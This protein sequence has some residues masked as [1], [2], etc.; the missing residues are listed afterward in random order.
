MTEM[1]DGSQG[2]I[3]VVLVTNTPFKCRLL[4]N[5]KTTAEPGFGDLFPNNNREKMMFYQ[6]LSKPALGL[7]I[8]KS[9][10]VRVRQTLLAKPLRFFVVQDHLW[11]FAGDK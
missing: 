5:S 1:K 3:P 4:E 9:P 7:V 6:T 11:D 2:M 10:W 8:A